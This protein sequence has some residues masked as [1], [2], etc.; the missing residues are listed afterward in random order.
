MRYK[1]FVNNLWQENTI[2]LYDESGE[3]AVVDCGC[4]GKEEE[5]RMQ[6]FFS[7]QGLKPVLLLNTHLH[8]DHVFGN[9]FMKEVYGLSTQAAEEDVFLID[10]AVGFASSLGVRGMNQQPQVGTYLKHGDVVSFGNTK[11]QVIAVRGHSPG[12]LCFY[13]EADRLLISGDVL[14]AG[15]VGRSDFPG[16]NGKLLI[17]DIRNRLFVLPDEVKVIPGHGPMTTIEEEKRYNPFF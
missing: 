2:V 1:I 13:S 7:A 4:W 17:E 5:E 16:G 12:G 3:A 14:F 8:P 11:L 6:E 10:N 15:S 9:H